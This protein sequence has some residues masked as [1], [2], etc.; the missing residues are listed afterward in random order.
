MLD[1]NEARI[2]GIFLPYMKSKRE[3]AISATQRFSHY[4]SADSAMKMLSNNEVWLRKSSVMNDFSEIEYGISCLTTAWQSEAGIRFKQ[5]LDSMFPGSPGRIEERFNQQL[6]Q[7]RFDTYLACISEHDPSE[8]TFGRLSMWRAY[9][10]IALVLNPAVFM[11]QTV[12][13]LQSYSI[14]VDYHTPLSFQVAF[15]AMVGRA[16]YDSDFLKAQGE[17]TIW[18]WVNFMM[19]QLAL[20][21]KHKGFSEER[22]WR[23]IHTPSPA[24]SPLI[25]KGVEAIR[26]VAQPVVKLKLRNEPGLGVFG[27]DVASL[28]ERII[29]GP[30]QYPVAQ[31][32]AFAMLLENQG[33]QNP[34]DRIWVSD[35]PLR[36]Q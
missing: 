14:P 32:E 25:S 18:N 31:R 17:V 10:N 21:T 36:Q 4:T 29:I 11:Q 7:I 16:Q 33:V 19:S 35:I 1:S 15:D 24:Q 12:P 27:L 30:T 5:L 6:P 23:I 34:Y 9:G 20:C 3:A 26:N 2:L 28:V 22:E 8:N 13:A